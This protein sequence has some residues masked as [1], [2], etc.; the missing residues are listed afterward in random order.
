MDSYK[1]VV[2]AA[3]KGTRMNSDIPKVLHKICGS[4]MLNILLDT[5]FTAG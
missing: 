1:A 5:T 4:E 3:G 2:L